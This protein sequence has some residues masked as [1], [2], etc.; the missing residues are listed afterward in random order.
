[1]FIRVYRLRTRE[2]GEITHNKLV[3]PHTNI[4]LNRTNVATQAASDAKSPGL[5]TPTH[6]TTHFH[7]M[8]F[9]FFPLDAHRSSMRE[10]LYVSHHQ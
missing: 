7:K 4:P 9:A 6:A 2:A 10:A 3:V 8:I 1:M 5:A